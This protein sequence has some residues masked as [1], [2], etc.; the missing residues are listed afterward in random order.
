MELW[1]VGM[2]GIKIEN[3]PGIMIL[4]VN[5]FSKNRF[6]SI[7]PILPVF[8][9]STKS[10]HGSALLNWPNLKDKIFSIDKLIA[11]KVEYGQNT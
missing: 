4:D 6:H 3:L 5:A 1:K 9:C 11:A 7:E 2:L 8:R 10:I